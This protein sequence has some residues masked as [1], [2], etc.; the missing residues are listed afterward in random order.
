MECPLLLRKHPAAAF[1][2]IQN[3]MA[4]GVV[5]AVSSFVVAGPVFY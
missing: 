5:L 4:I 3:R 1:L 2:V